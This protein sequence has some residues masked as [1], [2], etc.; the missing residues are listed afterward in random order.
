MKILKAKLA[1]IF[2][3]IKLRLPYF[4]PICQIGRKKKNLKRGMHWYGPGYNIDLNE[5]LTKFRKIQQNIF[6][7]ISTPIL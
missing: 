2:F 6:L 5:N 3:A 1:E 4:Y 7:V